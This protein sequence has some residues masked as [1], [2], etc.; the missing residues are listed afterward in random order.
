MD[1][2]L[3]D[4]RRCNHRPHVVSSTLAV[5]LLRRKCFGASICQLKLMVDLADFDDRNFLVG[6]A[7]IEKKR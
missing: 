7:I 1:K 3:D 4:L 6:A 5:P 2:I